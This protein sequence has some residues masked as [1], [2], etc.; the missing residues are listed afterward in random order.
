M[1]IDC[2]RNSHT[3]VSSQKVI[4]VGINAVS[5]RRKNRRKSWEKLSREPRLVAVRG[6]LSTGGRFG[7]LKVTTTSIHPQFLQ[8]PMLQLP[9]AY[10]AGLVAGGVLT[11]PPDGLLVGP[12]TDG[13][14]PRA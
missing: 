9:F 5:P 13:A 14:P 6:P 3:L 1:P 4:S 8:I 10:F 12:L 7:S 11:F 2:Q